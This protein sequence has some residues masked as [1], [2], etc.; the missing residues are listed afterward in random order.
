MSVPAGQWHYRVNDGN[1]FETEWYQYGSSDPKIGNTWD[2]QGQNRAFVYPR[3]SNDLTFP[4]YASDWRLF[5]YGTASSLVNVKVYQNG[6]LRYNTDVIINQN[7]YQYLGLSTM[8]TLAS[9]DKLY[10][11]ATQ[12]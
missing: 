9:G 10:F 4:V 3:Y 2:L 8:L 12:L 7:G 11:K 6:I 5:V 1:K